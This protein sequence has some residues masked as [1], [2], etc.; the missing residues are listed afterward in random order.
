MKIYISGPIAGRPDGNRQSFASCERIIYEAGHE[1][2]NPQKVNHEH[3]GECFG[4]YVARQSCVRCQSLAALSDR[5]GPELPT[6][7]GI[8]QTDK[9]SE[10]PHRYGCYMKADIIALM[11]CDGIVLLHDWQFSRGAKVEMAVAEILGIPRLNMYD[12][13]VPK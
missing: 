5:Y 11:E 2:I 8:G 9:C 6:L 4:D 3:K 13:P 7:F 12:L 1:P 10:H